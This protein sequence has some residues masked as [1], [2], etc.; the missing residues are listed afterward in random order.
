MSPE[1]MHAE[2]VSL[3]LDGVL[4]YA[5]KR[6]VDRSHRR[7]QFSGES[8]EGAIEVSSKPGLFV[9]NPVTRKSTE[10]GLEQ[11]FNTLDAQRKSAEC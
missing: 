11:E 3:L 4:G 9:T 6:K 7:S 8:V 10:E 2:L 1:Q 5:A